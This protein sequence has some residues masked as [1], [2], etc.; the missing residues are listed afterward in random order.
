MLGI[1]LAIALGNETIRVCFNNKLYETKAPMYVK[2][3]DD[4]PV[5]FLHKAVKIS[6]KPCLDL[7]H[8]S[9]LCKS[10]HE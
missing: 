3:E 7:R 6:D 9:A 10:C 5:M 8:V 2:T 4:I 1:L